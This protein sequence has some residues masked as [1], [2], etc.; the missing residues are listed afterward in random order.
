MIRDRWIRSRRLDEQEIAWGSLGKNGIQAGVLFEPR[1]E[2]YAVGSVSCPGSSIATLVCRTSRL[3]SNVTTHSYYDKLHVV[4][5]TAPIPIDQILHRAARGWMRS[6][7]PAGPCTNF[8][9]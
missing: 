9:V 7:C 3:T 1:N 4:D 8:Q 5:A 2:V 6:T